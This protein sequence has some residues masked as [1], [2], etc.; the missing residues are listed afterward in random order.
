MNNQRNCLIVTY[1]RPENVDF[2]LRQMIK[3]KIDRVFLAVDGPKDEIDRKIQLK[4]QSIVNKYTNEGLNIDYWQRN[5]NLGVGLSVIT[6]IDWFFENCEEGI[7]LE[8]DLQLSDSFF[9]Y[10][11]NALNKYRNN[12][13]VK[14]ISGSRLVQWGKDELN[15]VACNYPQIWGWATWRDDWNALKK[16]YSTNFYLIFP[17]FFPVKSF[18]KAGTLRALSRKI[19][20]WDLP[21]AYIFWKMKFLCVIPPVNMVSN[22]GV[23][24]V[25]QHTFSNGF[26]LE[27]SIFELTSFYLPTEFSGNSIRAYNKALDSQVYGIKFRN[28]FSNTKAI[29][30]FFVSRN[31][32]RDFFKVNV[33]RRELLKYIS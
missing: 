18:W 9:N 31:F 2:L 30:E 11:F 26:P 17:S 23:D 13:N 3:N 25:A 33:L 22:I 27:L 8:D 1:A 21:L 5:K 24:K 28:V 20:T 12:P 15:A 32:N 14:M 16:T 6:A 7:V 19:D 29:F 10:C 4:Y